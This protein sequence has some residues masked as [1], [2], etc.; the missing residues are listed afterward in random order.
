MKIYYRRGSSKIFFKKDMPATL[1]KSDPNRG[2]VFSCGICEI[3]KNTFSYRTPPAAA[4][5]IKWLQ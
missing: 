1:V 5:V 2:E 4:S 3:F